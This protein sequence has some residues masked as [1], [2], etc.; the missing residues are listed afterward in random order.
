MFAN[1]SYTKKC[2]ALF[3]ALLLF[4][5]LGYRLS[6]SDTFRLVD[7]IHTKETKLQWLK[8]KEKE[9][10]ALKAKMAEFEKAY[11]RGDSSSVRDK[12]TAYISDFAEKNNCLVTEIPQ[13]S[14]FK[15]DKLRVQTNTFTI[16]GNFH[17][18]LTLLHKME[19]DYKYV[20]RI[21]S[22]RFFSVRDLQTKKKNLY[23]TLITQSFEQ[24][25][26]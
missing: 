9:L 1:L 23:L 15:N 12:L 20:S 19:T 24:K 14:F 4:F 10:P 7:E 16:K 17:S 6:F 22:A 3:G 2:Y 18:L 13:H 25:M 8:D 21:M 5:T 26:K 11:A